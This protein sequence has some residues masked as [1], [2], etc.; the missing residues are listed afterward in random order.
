MTTHTTEPLWD[1]SIY[2]LPPRICLVAVSVAGIAFVDTHRH[3]GES[4]GNGLIL[5]EDQAE[6]P[7]VNLDETDLTT[8]T[9]E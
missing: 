7:F 5:T 4:F 6:I 1:I 2:H 8:K 3:L 9:H